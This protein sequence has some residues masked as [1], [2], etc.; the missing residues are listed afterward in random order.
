MSLEEF[1]LLRDLVYEHAGLV[2]DESALMLFDRRLGERLEALGLP[3]YQAYYK[4][5][6]FDAHN[7]SEMEEALER[8]TTKETYFFRQEYQ[9]RAFQAELLPRLEQAN[10]RSRRLLV[11]SAGCSTGEEAYTIAALI[12]ESAR[13]DGWDVR[14]I[15][16]DLSRHCVAHARRGVYQA[17]SLRA[18]SAKDKARYFFELEDGFHVADSVKKLC[19]FGQMNLFD[20]GRGNLVGRVDA[21]FCR[22]VLIYFDVRSRKRVIDNLYQRL[23]PGGYLMLGHSESLLN[24]STAFE[25]VHL[26]DDLVYRRPVGAGGLA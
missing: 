15:G 17:S 20:S 3:S 14:V 18:T 19:Q 8:L 25:L 7:Q 5:L 23:C 24:L 4:Y 1:R 16:T 13:F 11:W 6:R 2:Y 9:L 10:A 22:N 12:L 21:I 26:R